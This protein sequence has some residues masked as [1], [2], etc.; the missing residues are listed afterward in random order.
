MGDWKKVYRAEPVPLGRGTFATVHAARHRVT[1]E[2]VAVKCIRAPLPDALSRLS[3]EIRVT[4][5]LAHRNVMPV[6]CDDP[7][8]RWYSMPR[9]D[10]SLTARVSA[11]GPLEDHDI[12]GF[13][14]DTIA[15]LQHAHLHCCVHRDLSPNNVLWLAVPAPSRWVIADWGQVLDGRSTSKRRTRPQDAL[16]TDGYLAPEGYDDITS[17]GFDSDIY[18]LGCLV[19]FACTGTHPKPNQPLHPVGPWLHFVRRA[20]EVERTRR[21][22]IAE[23]SSMLDRGTASTRPTSDLSFDASAGDER[24]A[25]ELMRRLAAQ[26]LSGSDIQSLCTVDHR[27]ALRIMLENHHAAT[28]LAQIR[29]LIPHIADAGLLESLLQWHQRAFAAARAAEMKTELARNILLL[30]S[31]HHAD[32]RQAVLGWVVLLGTEETGPVEQVLEGSPTLLELY[33]QT[34]SSEVFAPASSRIR[35]LFALE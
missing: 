23:L 10:Y 21:A 28:V 3:R 14:S 1:D 4:K 16:G 30:G 17:L 31:V 19:A 12:E 15:G 13:L 9:C 24:A 2:A 27:R 26:R 8:G 32:Y 18:S 25:R 20:T 34:A 33:R 29:G 22:T 5:R 7:N 11:L 35:K 6:I